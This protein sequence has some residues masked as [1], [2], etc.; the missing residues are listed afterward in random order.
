MLISCSVTIFDA[1]LQGWCRVWLGMLSEPHAPPISG[2]T[3][4]LP[5]LAHWHELSY[6]HQVPQVTFL[7]HLSVGLD[8]RDQVAV[9][10]VK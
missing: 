5:A 10:I 8:Y 3:Q 7:L 9:I 6:S 1:P 2:A 4:Q